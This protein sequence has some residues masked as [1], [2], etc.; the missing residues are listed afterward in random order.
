[1][2]GPLQ[3]IRKLSVATQE[4]LAEANSVAEEALSSMATVRSF[5]C[6]GDEGKAADE[7]MRA[8]FAATDE[9]GAALCPA[10]R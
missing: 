9:R 4:K 7:T 1:L 8:R 6:E 5:A 3:Y 10:G 2:F